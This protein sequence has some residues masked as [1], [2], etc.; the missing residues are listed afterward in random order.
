MQHGFNPSLSHSLCLSVSAC[1]YIYI[2]IHTHTYSTSPNAPLE[3]VWT[4]TTQPKYNLRKRLEQDM[5]IG[6]YTLRF[7]DL[8]REREKDIGVSINGDTQN[9]WFQIENPMKID[10]N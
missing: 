10:D 7:L 9:G 2:Y 8:E 4:P 1:L 5:Y 6:G 3:G